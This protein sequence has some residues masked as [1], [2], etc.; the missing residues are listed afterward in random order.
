[1]PKS[2][3]GGGPVACSGWLMACLCPP[4]PSPPNPRDAPILA[5]S[6]FVGH[7]CTTCW[8][9]KPS[10]Q[11]RAAR[12][13]R[14]TIRAGSDQSGGSHRRG[15]EWKHHPAR[16]HTTVRGYTAVYSIFDK[17]FARNLNTDITAHNILRG[18]TY[19]CLR[20]MNVTSNR[21]LEL[22]EEKELFRLRKRV[23]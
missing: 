17:A 2:G 16:N 8:T 6:V 15:E 21:R 20:Q 4:P 11:P 13:K 14:K 9:G 1:M 12:P 18:W 3:G 23:T 5:T 7:V 10:R 22:V 19:Q